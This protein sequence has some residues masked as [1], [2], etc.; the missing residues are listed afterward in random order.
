MDEHLT[1]KRVARAIG[2]SEASLKRWCD[3]GLIQTV[4]TAGGHRRL[5]LASVVSFIRSTGHGV[6]QPDVL[7]LPAT[8]GYGDAIF[9]RGVEKLTD[10]LIAGNHEVARSVVFDLYLFGRP[11]AEICDRIVT[12]ALHTVGEQWEH[13]QAEV[14]QERRGIEICTRLLNEILRLTTPPAADAPLA[15]GAALEGD[16]YTVCG[17]MCELVL[18]DAGWRA[19]WVGPHVPAASLV[20]AMQAKAPRMFWLCVGSPPERGHFLGEYGQ[21]SDAATRVGATIAV[22]G[23]GL[24]PDLRQEMRFDRHCE[25]LRGLVEFAEASLNGV[26]ADEPA[27]FNGP[28]D[29]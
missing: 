10:A 8:S 26:T 14:Y 5:S 20:A 22:G 3:K 2:V 9:Q 6:V 7:G 28:A 12:P 24:T 13:G 29:K 4:R 21:L 1:P 11:I 17:L 18:R 19:E 27:D 16:H 25:D 15:L 23:R